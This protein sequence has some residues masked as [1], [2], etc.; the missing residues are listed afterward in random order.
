MFKAERK[1]EASS[2]IRQHD[3]RAF[4]KWLT[5]GLFAKAAQVA[6]VPMRGSPLCLIKVMSSDGWRVIAIERSSA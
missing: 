2:E 4:G 1:S 3:L 6:Q 5:P